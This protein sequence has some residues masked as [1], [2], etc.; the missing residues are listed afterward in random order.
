MLLVVD[1]DFHIAVS[2]GEFSLDKDN[3]NG[4]S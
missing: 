4:C 3:M 2:V 1:R